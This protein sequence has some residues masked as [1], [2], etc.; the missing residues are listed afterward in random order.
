MAKRRG[1]FLKKLK[2]DI[3]N[4]NLTK[5]HFYYSVL[6]LIVLILSIFL[7]N[8][9]NK[10]KIY[11]VN[12]KSDTFNV[13]NGLIVVTD[14]DCIVR[15]SNITY[16]GG[17][18]NVVSAHLELYVEVNG[19]KYLLNEFGANSGEGFNLNDYINKLNFN[20][21]EDSNS[22]DVITSKIRKN[23]ANNLYLKVKMTSVDGLDV[24][25]T[26]DLESSLKYQNSKLFY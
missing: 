9:Y 12:A 8:N 18:T 1:K 21:L 5:H 3:K 14:D 25:E 20:I 13:D 7:F 10:C 19:K 2:K 11:Y 16:N 6:A 22:T 4:I 24:E 15:I 26:I 23:I 17:I